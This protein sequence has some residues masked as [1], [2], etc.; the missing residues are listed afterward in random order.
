ME[1]ELRGYL[2]SMV[3]FLLVISLLLFLAFI[4]IPTTNNDV[5]KLVLGVIAGSLS[6]VMLTISG[7]DSSEVENLKIDNQKLIIE[8]IELSKRVDQL[9]S[10]FRDLQGKVIDKLAILVDKKV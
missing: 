5:F 3:V 7:R 4:E 8:N 9:E 6:T 10:M 1:K 2:G